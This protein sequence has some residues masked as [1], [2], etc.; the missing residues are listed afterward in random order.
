MIHTFTINWRKKTMTL[1][2]L[3]KILDALPEDTQVY[4][5]KGETFKVITTLTIEH[6][7]DE[8]KTHIVFSSYE[9]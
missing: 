9:I 5:K 2:T 8:E 3:K 6:D 7:E 4:V 1:E